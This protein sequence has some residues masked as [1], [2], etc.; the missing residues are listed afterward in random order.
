MLLLIPVLIGIWFINQWLTK[1]RLKNIGSP[2]ILSV[3]LPKVSFIYAVVKY[4][5][6][7]LGITI[8]IIALTNPQTGE[9]STTSRTVGFEVN[10]V[11][12]VS[13]SMLAEDIKPSRM[14]AVRE[15]S[16][17]L[18]NGLRDNRIG[19]TV[20]AGEAFNQIP[21]TSDENILDAVLS[22]LSPEIV[23]TQGSDLNKAL[24]IALQ[25]FNFQEKDR[26]FL[27][28]LTDGESHEGDFMEA[29][30][31]AAEQGVVIHVIGV[32]TSK[33]AVVPVKLRNGKSVSLKD[34]Q[35][36]VV[37]SALDEESLQTLAQEGQGV[38]SKIDDA[39][40][41]KRI[42]NAINGHDKRIVTEKIYSEYS[43]YFPYLIAAAL[44]LI[45]LEFLMPKY[46]LTRK[47]E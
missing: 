3:I 24:E 14:E 7:V 18:I 31:K 43:S 2:Q 38:Y 19:I 36:K 11:I 6:L 25:N 30:K 20:F 22:T 29:A 37:I 15:I 45:L 1:R 12:D 35:G 41:I 16:F 23:P 27:I 13:N 21:P 46:K 8:L 10:L 26:K 33:G 40:G 39:D 5:I 17:K 9:E 44:V 32:G 42:I 34:N 4:S 47:G 28:V